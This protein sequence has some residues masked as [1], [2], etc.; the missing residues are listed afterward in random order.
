MVVLGSPVL[1]AA[2]QA[3][4][5]PPPASKDAAVHCRNSRWA[6]ANRGGGAACGSIVKV[7]A[8]GDAKYGSVCCAS[9]LISPWA[10]CQC[11]TSL[12]CRVNSRLRGLRV[13][14]L[15]VLHS[16]LLGSVLISGVLFGGEL[17]VLLNG[18][19]SRGCWL[20]WCLGSECSTPRLPALLQLVA[21]C[22]DVQ[23]SRNLAVVR[24]VCSIVKM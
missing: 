13:V 1:C 18:R 20:L 3:D 14:L 6:K 23:R 5:E 8:I 11:L 19:S 24:V 9:F 10:C 7:E 12:P 15:V 2:R 21:S 4:S 22:R 16:V 17:L